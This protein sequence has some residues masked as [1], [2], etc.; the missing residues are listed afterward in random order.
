M[1][2]R[3]LRLPM[4]C[5]VRLRISSEDRETVTRNFSYNNVGICEMQN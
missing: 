2:A 5:D 3:V 1:W 4:D